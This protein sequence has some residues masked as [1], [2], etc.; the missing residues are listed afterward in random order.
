MLAPGGRLF[1]YSHVRKNARIAKGLRFI[2]WTG[3]EARARR[4]S[5]SQPGA[6]AEI[7]SP[8]PAGRRARPAIAWSSG[9]GFRIEEIRYYTPIVGGFV[10]NILVRVGERVIG[11]RAKPPR[12]RRRRAGEPASREPTAKARI[13]KR[14]A[15]Y[16]GLA[17]LTWFMKLDVWLFG[18]I[19]SGP[20]FALLVKDR[21]A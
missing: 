14:G 10:E 9:A 15:V 12:C 21:P 8:Q 19:E 11:A 18:R 16:R 1:V 6:P 17:A 20:F 13:A 2:N 7:G 5:R 3:G 4:R